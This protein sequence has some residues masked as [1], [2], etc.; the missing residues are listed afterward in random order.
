M[1]KCRSRDRCWESIEFGNP[2]IAEDYDGGLMKLDWVE[3]E[4]DEGDR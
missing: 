2:Y 1:V 3:E 4:K